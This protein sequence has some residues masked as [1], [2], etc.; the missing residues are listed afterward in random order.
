MQHIKVYVFD[1]YSFVVKLN[2]KLCPVFFKKTFSGTGFTQTS[3]VKKDCA[4]SC[5]KSLLSVSLESN[6]ILDLLSSKIKLIPIASLSAFGG[7]NATALCRLSIT[8]TQCKL[9]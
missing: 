9:I 4:F 8:P 3:L 6:D 7:Y 1:N 5:Y 2:Q